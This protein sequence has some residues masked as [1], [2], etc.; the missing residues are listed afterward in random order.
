MMRAK[1]M[2]QPKSVSAAKEKPRGTK[3][4]RD[5]SRESSVS[6][7]DV[8]RQAL[9]AVA[10]AGPGPESLTAQRTEIREQI[11]TLEKEI[12]NLGAQIEKCDVERAEAKKMLD[13]EKSNVA[14]QQKDAA[15]AQ[16]WAFLAQERATQRDRVHAKEQDKRALEAA[17]RAPGRPPPTPEMNFWKAAPPAYPEGNLADLLHLTKLP[18]RERSLKQ[19]RDW[20]CYLA[21]IMGRVKDKQLVPLAATT[22]RSGSGKTEFFHFLRMTEDTR[23]ATNPGDVTPAGSPCEPLI[24]AINTQCTS[25]QHLAQFVTVMATFNQV[26]PYTSARDT[27]EAIIRMTCARFLFESFVDVC[28]AASRPYCQSLDEFVAEVRRTS[29]CANA[30]TVGILILVD[31]L[32]RIGDDTRRALMTELAEFQQKQLQDGFFT[33]VIISSLELS[34]VHDVLVR[35]SSRDYAAI[36]LPALAM[37]N[38][39]PLFQTLRGRFTDGSENSNEANQHALDVSVELTAG[40]PT[41]LRQVYDHF[42]KMES[43]CA[44]PVH[45]P[46]TKALKREHVDVLWVIMQR[47]LRFEHAETI[48]AAGHLEQKYQDMYSHGLL[49]LLPEPVA[50]DHVLRIEAT[51][52]S[53]I[54][55]SSNLFD[56]KRNP[57]QVTVNRV[58]AMLLTSSKGLLEK[59]WEEG[60]AGVLELHLAARLVNNPSLESF[61]NDIGATVQPWQRGGEDLREASPRKDAPGWSRVTTIDKYNAVRNNYT[62][63]VSLKKNEEAIE[64][65]MSLF[66]RN[67]RPVKFLAQHKLY[68]TTNPSQ[69]YGLVNRVHWRAK[70]LGLEPGTYYSLLLITG[71]SASAHADLQEGTILIGTESLEKLLSPLGASAIL[72]FVVNHARAPNQ[73]E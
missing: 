54:C 27:K 65:I 47:S 56:D 11:A 17:R 55:A 48:Q 41:S 31:E 51:P 29:G 36:D 24:T 64:L 43:K 59:E 12:V 70:N 38:S 49:Q 2:E 45:V 23:W 22:G 7:G 25:E 71:E 20:V 28:D 19:V 37:S 21:G 30:K 58:A 18:G 50:D 42:W 60:M 68:C 63:L 33:A 69:V 6:S 14:L 52:A 44:N 67:R 13:A 15:L 10:S 57:K 9:P 66:V 34:P 16:G 46:A 26:T 5:D 35:G 53:L 1:V 73:R 32:M 62:V 8:S 40:H 4:H 61:L 3:R 39:M 72:K